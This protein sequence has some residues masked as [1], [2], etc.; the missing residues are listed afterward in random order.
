M[1]KLGKKAV[2]L[3]KQLIQTDECYLQLTKRNATAAQELRD[4]NL[5]DFIPISTGGAN[6]ALGSAGI[7][8]AEE[9]KLNEN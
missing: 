6:I 8:E 5:V 1:T 3:L 2:S 7:A 4:A 9:R